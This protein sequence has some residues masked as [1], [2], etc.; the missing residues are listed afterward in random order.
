MVVFQ[1]DRSFTLDINLPSDDW[2]ILA[3]CGATAPIRPPS[4][5]SLD[6]C[7]I[8]QLG[9]LIASYGSLIAKLKAIIVDGI[10]FSFVMVLNFWSFLLSME[11]EPIEV[12]RTWLAASDC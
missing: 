7:S 1:K 9:Y 12:K 4:N 11:S 6:N 5:F 3:A 2:L 8:V 10:Y